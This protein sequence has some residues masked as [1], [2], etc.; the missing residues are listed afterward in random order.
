MATTDVSLYLSGNYAPVDDETTAIFSAGREALNLIAAK[1]SAYD[2][3]LGAQRAGLAVGV[4]YAPEEAYEDPHFRER[5][6][7]VEVDHPEL[8]RKGS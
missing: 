7:Q 1:L 8:G 6:F 4:I 3:F 2:F 5:G